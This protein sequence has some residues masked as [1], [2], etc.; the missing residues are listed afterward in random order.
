MSGGSSRG[1]G[2]KFI[3]S[4]R[5][6]DRLCGPPK[7]PTHWVPEDLSFEVKR[8]GREADHSYLVPRSGMRGGIPLI[9]PTRL[10]DVVLS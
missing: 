2:W 9:P 3:S 8:P 6:P 10:L 1:R 4:P 7:P 5:H